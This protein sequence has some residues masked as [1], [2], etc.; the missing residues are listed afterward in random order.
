[1]PAPFGVA[2]VRE[3]PVRADCSNRPVGV[4]EFHAFWEPHRW[5]LF[6]GPRRLG[7]AA[8]DWMSRTASV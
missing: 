2:A 3:I 7:R 1:V 8:S 4:F 6:N 5:L